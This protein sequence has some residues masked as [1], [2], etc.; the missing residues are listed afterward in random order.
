MTNESSWIIFF[1]FNFHI[2]IIQVGQCKHPTVTHHILSI[3]SQL[4]QEEL[5]CTSLENIC[6]AFPSSLSFSV[7]THKRA[8]TLSLTV[9]RFQRS[10]PTNSYLTASVKWIM[11]DLFRSWPVKGLVCLSERSIA[12]KDEG[13]AAESRGIRMS[14]E[15]SLS[16]VFGQS[17]CWSANVKI[18]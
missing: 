14:R 9:R 5:H 1:F 16:V 10:G 12:A 8:A 3:K 15:S 6:S 17:L 13:C 18:W 2:W 11:S 4:I 7:Q